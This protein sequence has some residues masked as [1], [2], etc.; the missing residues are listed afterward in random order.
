MASASA[1]SGAGCVPLA[2]VRVLRQLR[3]PH[4]ADRPQGCGLPARGCELGS[5]SP[6]LPVS[7]RALQSDAALRRSGRPDRGRDRSAWLRGLGYARTPR[8][9]SRPSRPAR[10]PRHAAPLCAPGPRQAPPTSGSL[11][12]ALPRRYEPRSLAR[13]RVQHP[14]RIGC[15]PASFLARSDKSPRRGD[16]LLLRAVLDGVDQSPHPGPGTWPPPSSRPAAL[17]RL[18]HPRA[19]P[20]DDRPMTAGGLTG[21]RTRPADATLLRRA[22]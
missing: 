19:Q 7:R 5:R 20:G 21:A 10:A 4:R 15:R 11:G 3:E 9:A 18:A 6:K 8:T 17:P 16:S 12:P 14:P 1:V 2:Y 13:S 22:P